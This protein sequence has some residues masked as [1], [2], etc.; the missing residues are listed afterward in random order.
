MTTRKVL[1]RTWN[2]YNAM[3][4]V[5]AP[6]ICQAELVYLWDGQ[7]V[8]TVLHFSNTATLTPTLMNELG[9]HL[10]NWF[11]TQID[12]Q[13]PSVKTLTNIKLTDLTTN[14]APVVNYATGL[15]L[16]G[17]SA[18]VSLPNN[19]ALVITKRTLLRGRSYRGRIYHPGLTESNVT[20]NQ[21]SSVYVVNTIAIYSLLINFTTASATWDMVVVSRFEGGSPRVTAD[22]NQVTTL[23]S[24]G[25]VDSQ[26]RRLPKRGS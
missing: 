16:N 10:V 6:G 22:S 5:P 4:Y 1:G 21:V 18:G 19:C 17:V 25:V 20:A 15:P 24:D 8:E 9:A 7:V 3:P 11:N 2:R 26:R 13:L 12:L 14:I 23:D